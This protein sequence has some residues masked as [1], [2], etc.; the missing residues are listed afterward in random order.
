[1]QSYDWQKKTWIQ[2]KV[3]LEELRDVLASGGRHIAYYPD[4]LWEDKPG[5]S[6]I[7]LE[8]STETYPFMKGN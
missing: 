7:R 1:M 5:L 4:N 3:L 6:T 2:D 8:M